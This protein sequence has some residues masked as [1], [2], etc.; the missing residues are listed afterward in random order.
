MKIIS[1][2]KL[3]LIRSSA[4]LESAEERKCDLLLGLFMLCCWKDHG[5]N[6]V[7]SSCKT[8]FLR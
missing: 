3:F 5:R 8:M 4:F 6:E 1:L 7:L 2:R